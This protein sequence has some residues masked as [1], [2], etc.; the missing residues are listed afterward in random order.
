MTEQEVCNYCATVLKEV[1]NDIYLS[2]IPRKPIQL[3]FKKLSP[4]AKLPTQ[5]Y[6]TDAGWDFYA[7]E[8]VALL[9]NQP[10]MVSLG[11]A[12][13]I[14]AGFYMALQDRSGLA[15]QGVGRLAGIIDSEYRGEWKAILVNHTESMR[16]INRGEK[17]IQG[18]LCQVIPAE[19]AEVPDGED[20]PQSA[21]GEKGFGSS[22]KGV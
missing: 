7:N 14:P 4:T 13:V 5:A 9:T 21:R 19:I 20:L 11:I 18:I 2:E 3:Q 8:E 10:T 15:S 17:C 12:S 22:G 6:P 16:V 1:C